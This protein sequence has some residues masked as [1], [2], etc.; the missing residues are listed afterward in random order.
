MAK[1]LINKK[2]NKNIFKQINL[3]LSMLNKRGDVNWMLISLVIGIIVLVV[4]VLG[5]STNWQI[6]SSLFPTNN[7][8][9]V[10]SQCQTACATNSV[11]GFC[12]ETKTL[13]AN[14]LPPVNDEKVNEVSNTCQ[15]F[16]KAIEFSK[17][18]IANCPG[19]SCP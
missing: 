5:F 4:L 17:Y 7:V 6:F 18:G 12:T 2:I 13:K 1:A 14:D 15:Y 19:I 10:K 11:Y 9:T 3:I 8:D 16:S